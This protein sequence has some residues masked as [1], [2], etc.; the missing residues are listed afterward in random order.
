MMG[1]VVLGLQQIFYNKYLLF[2]YVVIGA[3]VFLLA[4]RALRAVRRED[5]DLLSD[6]LGPKMKFITRW[7][8]KVL[9]IK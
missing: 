3:L 5:I 9:D 6:F 1:V 4:L 7:L 2:L 8:G